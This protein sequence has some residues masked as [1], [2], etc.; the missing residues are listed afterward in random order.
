MRILHYIKIRNFKIFGDE[1]EV[2]LD[3]PSVL[4]GPNNSG[5][6]SVL[7]ALAL[8]SFGVKSWF[9]SKGETKAT[10]NLSSGI[11]RLN[12]TQLPVQNARFL[13]NNTEVRKGST[14]LIPL[15]ITVGVEYNGKVHDCSMSFTQLS[16]EIIYCLPNKSFYEDKPLM[17]FAS[18]I[19]VNLLYS[20]SGVAIEEVLLPEGRINSLI[21]QGQTSEVLRNLCYMIYEKENKEDWKE[22][23]HLIERLFQIQLQPPK[24]IVSRGVIEL[25]YRSNDVKNNLDIAMAGRGLQQFLLLFSYLYSHKSSVLLLDEPDAHLEILRQKTIYTVLKRL[26]EKNGNQLIIATH[27]EVILNEASDTNLELILVGEAIHLAEKDHI[28]KTLRNFGI[29]HYY[30]AKQKKT[31]LYVEGSTDIDMLKEFARLVNNDAA[32]ELLDSNLNYYYTQ[33]TEPDDTTENEIDRDHG[34][35][36]ANFRTHFKALK[37][38]VPDFKGVAVLD[39]D[40]KQ[41]T[42][43]RDDKFTT[44]YWKRY[45]LEN[46]FVKPYVLEKWATDI[47]QIKGTLFEQF[48]QEALDS[49][50][51]E[52]VFNNNKQ[53]LKEF[54]ALT[55]ALKDSYWIN[56][57]KNIKLSFFL[58]NVLL[59]Y[60]QLSSQPIPINKGQFYELIKYL[61]VD[62]V[63]DEIKNVLDLIVEYLTVK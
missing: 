54:K 21:G 33:N 14:E 61:P 43:E 58:E 6:T 56:I 10:K 23:V 50:M 37:S 44:V 51:L 52:F 30:K 20:M 9:Q 2:K 39:G 28:K 15:E 7:Q 32:F 60:S 17:N 35:Y 45:E 19:N 25:K 8:W 27:S 36:S 59:K 40:G 16:A 4:I 57:T 62:Q 63:D 41:R 42:S 13:W 1:I 55:S 46:Y 29:E 38:V 22:M 11:N 5:K 24:F 53:A 26:T 18:T 12:L 3:Q 31:I 47:L 49:C 34:Y 48:F